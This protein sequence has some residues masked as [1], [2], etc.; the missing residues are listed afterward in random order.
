MKRVRGLIGT[1]R[2]R[3]LV[4]LRG[5]DWPAVQS[6]QLEQ[7]RQ[8]SGHGAEALISRFGQIDPS[9]AGGSEVFGIIKQL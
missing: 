4:G 5:H 1:S 3:I 2:D 6:H 8:G 7:R 9:M